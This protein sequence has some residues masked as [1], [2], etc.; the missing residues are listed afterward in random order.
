MGNKK[1]KLDTNF[2][3][4][5]SLPWLDSLLLSSTVMSTQ[6]T[7]VMWEIFQLLKTV[8]SYFINTFPHPFSLFLKVNNSDVG[9]P[10]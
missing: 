1:E 10:R 7:L 4:P 6:W 2:H 3:T 9:T 8:L 5:K